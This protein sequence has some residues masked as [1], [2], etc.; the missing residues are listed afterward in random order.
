MSPEFPKVR[1]APQSVDAGWVPSGIVLLDAAIVRLLERGAAD[2]DVVGPQGTYRVTNVPQAPV[3]TPGCYCLP[4]GVVSP[5]PPAPAENLTE[6][7]AGEADLDEGA[8]E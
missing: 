8:P 1:Y 7:E 2:L 3:P 4:A 6:V 5:Y